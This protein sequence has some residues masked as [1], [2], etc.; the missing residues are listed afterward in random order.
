MPPCGLLGRLV[1]RPEWDLSPVPHPFPIDGRVST[2]SDKYQK[3]PLSLDDLQTLEGR[4]LSR[5]VAGT[6]ILIQMSDVT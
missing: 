5:G 2:L 4:S 6:C 1:T 3:A